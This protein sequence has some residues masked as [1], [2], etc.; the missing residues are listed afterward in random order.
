M[1][2]NPVPAAASATGTRS[3]KGNLITFVNPEVPLVG[4]VAEL[5]MV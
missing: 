2:T 1:S 3:G 4:V 5:A